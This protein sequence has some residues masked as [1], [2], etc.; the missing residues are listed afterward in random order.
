QVSPAEH[1]KPP[2]GELAS[3]CSPGSS[4]PLPQVPP[5]IVVVVDPWTGLH[6]H[7]TGLQSQPG[8]QNAPP[9]ELGSH[10]SPGSTLPLPHVLPSSVVVVRVVVTCGA[11][12]VVL[13][14]VVVVPPPLTHRH[15]ALQ[16]NPGGHENAP[17]GELA[18]HSSPGSS[19]PLPQSDDETIVVV[20]V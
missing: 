16:V 12:V 15:A 20:V 2:D 17:P 8:G 7:V 13:F 4:L 11:E 5:G 6:V 19:F 18:S 9:G 3:H 10:S 14:M 1:V